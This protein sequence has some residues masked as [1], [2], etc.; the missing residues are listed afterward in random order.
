MET[1]IVYVEDTAPPPQDT[2]LD[3]L[4]IWVDSFTQPNSMNGMDI[5]WVI[6]RSG[7]MQMKLLQITR[8]R[9][10]DEC[11][12]QTQWRLVMINISSLN[13]VN[14]QDFP[15]V[16]GDTLADAGQCMPVLAAQEEKKVLNHSKH[17]FRTILIHKHG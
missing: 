17:I 8:H 1:E 7:S 6:D 3:L 9:N 5:I 13:S 4:P 14:H 10:Y 2:S 11:S 16:P 12:T 15:L